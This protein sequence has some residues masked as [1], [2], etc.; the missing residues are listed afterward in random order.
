VNQS[1]LVE[2][3]FAALDPMRHLQDGGVELLCVARLIPTKRVDVAI[4]TVKV[5]RDRGVDSHLRVMGVG[6]ERPSLEAL[7]RE[8]D[9]TQSVQMRGF[10][11]DRKS[12]REEYRSAFALL[13]PSEREGISLAVQEAMAA[14]VI[15][16]STPAGGL[17]DFLD[18][19]ATALVVDGP[20][21]EGFAD[22]VEKL[23]A[24]PELAAAIVERGQAKVRGATNE[25][26][27]RQFEA[28]A[29]EVRRA[30]PS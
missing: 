15:V 5:L 29:T 1:T 10:L 24:S 28:L 3:D 25:A 8:L 20:H 9:L 4:K 22:A 30:K 21:P 2:E 7:I 12:I 26:W 13:L 23:I 14:G 6:P 16:I 17:R 11:D 18:H 27:L 19:E